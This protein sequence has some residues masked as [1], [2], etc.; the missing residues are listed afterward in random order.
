M[1]IDFEVK[2]RYI[3]INNVFYND[4]N[5]RVIIKYVCMFGCLVVVFILCNILI[6]DWV[7]Y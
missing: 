2:I 5:L 4:F 7:S 3:F 1:N 6:R